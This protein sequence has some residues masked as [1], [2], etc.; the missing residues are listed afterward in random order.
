MPARFVPAPRC[1]ESRAPSEPAQP[2]HLALNP[3]PAPPHL[4]GV[5]VGFALRVRRARPFR[6]RRPGV[7]F[8]ESP[9]PLEHVP[10]PF[11]RR[12]PLPLPTMLAARRRPFDDPLSRED[13][14]RPRV[15]HAQ[16]VLF[17]RETMEVPNRKIR[18]HL[19]LQPTY[20]RDGPFGYARR[21]PLPG[22][23]VSRALNPE[24]SV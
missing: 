19:P 16:L 4:C 2:A 23:T 9:P 11:E 13:V 22:P 20:L 6:S 10:N 7:E 14:S 18:V 12:T 3:A 24:P 21:L 1:A 17:H 15:T 5:T 8:A